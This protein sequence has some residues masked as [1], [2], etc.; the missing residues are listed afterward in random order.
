MAPRSLTT[1]MLLKVRPNLVKRPRRRPR[2]LAGGGVIVAGGELRE[3]PRRHVLFIAVVNQVAGL[4]R[5]EHDGAACAY[6]GLVRQAA[7]RVDILAGEQRE[8]M[9]QN[10]LAIY[11]ALDA[12]IAPIEFAVFAGALSKGKRLKDHR[13]E[14][15]QAQRDLFDAEAV[16]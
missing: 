11:R 8:R 14:R 16:F 12:P 2:D 3:Q 5:V 1:L 4:R 6:L 9:A 15:H 7:I 10:S 13:N